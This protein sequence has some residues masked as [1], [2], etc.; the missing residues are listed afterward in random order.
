MKK[1]ELLERIGKDAPGAVLNVEDHVAAGYI[2]AGLARSWTPPPLP[3]TTTTLPS[4]ES[5][6][7]DLVEAEADKRAGWTDLVGNIVRAANRADLD[8]ADTA[9]RVLRGV[10]GMVPSVD[11]ATGWVLGARELHSRPADAFRRNLAEAV[12][13][14]GGYLT[15]VTYRDQ[16]LA[17]AREVEV[18]TSRA[19]AVPMGA[20]QVE[21][22]AFDQY[23]A[24]AAG[25]PA[26]F[27][28]IKAYRKGE[29]AQR[30]AADP[31]IRMVSLI[32]NDLTSYVELSRDLMQDSPQTTD[33]TLPRALGWALGWR[34]D[35]EVQNGNA[36]GQF[37]GIV[38]S[39]ATI[40]IAR[41]TAGHIAYGDV[42]AM[43]ARMTPCDLPFAAWY[44][45]PNGLVDLLKLKGEAGENVYVPAIAPAVGSILPGLQVGVLLG[46]PV[47]ATEKMSVLGTAGDFG[48][49]AMRRYL[50]GDMTGVEIGL[51]EHFK[52][53]TDQASLR[54]KVRNAG[55]P[56]LLAPIPL[57]D[58]T[59]STVS[60]FISLT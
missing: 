52:F 46:L 12:G 55:A 53:D 14:T 60:S 39:P 28:G 42:V 5:V 17:Y 43:F 26:W 30:T 6:R 25:Q 16:L 38:N 27:G 48:L 36:L 59:G 57:S 3:A 51:S 35:W 15:K 33:V 1:V 49:Y 11:M 22:P 23:T 40:G 45:H 13:T 56:E 20:R 58:G 47:L 37:L 32:A 8:A 18:F 34:T 50:H 19:T 31:S 29:A 2:R 7:A 9:H 10:Y 41:G 54:A 24:A 4:A 21:V 44:V